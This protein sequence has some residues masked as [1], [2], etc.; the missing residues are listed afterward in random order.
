MSTDQNRSSRIGQEGFTLLEI[1]VAVCI[2]AVGLL[3]V[4]SMQTTAIRNNYNASN[5]T[6]G[7]TVAQDRLERFLAQPYNMADEGALPAET[8]GI[9]NV[10]GAVGRLD[11]V[12]PN[13]GQI[14]TVTVTW[15]DKGVNKTSQLVSIKP[16]L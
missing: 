14:I 2:L 12:D 5:I 16:R 7:T 15:Q 3:A 1:I 11:A 9:Y 8:T 6:E 4:A 10:N 13:Q